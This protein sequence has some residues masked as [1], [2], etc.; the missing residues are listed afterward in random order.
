M[1][2]NTV[3][4]S[5]ITPVFNSEKFIARCI[6]SVQ[7]Q[8]F[9][10]YEYLII[11]GGSTDSTVAKIARYQ[12]KDSRIKI[13]SEHDEGVYDAMNKGISISKGK[14]M[15]FLGSDDYFYSNT[16]LDTIS[17]AITKYNTDI[18]Y[19]DVWHEQLNSVY[20]GC[21][22]IEKLLKHNICHQAIFFKKN[23]FDRIGKYSLKY[24]KK[25]DYNFNLHCW[26]N[27]VKHVYYNEV[28]AFYSTGGLSSIGK[29]VDF[30]KDYPIN[31]VKFLFESIRKPIS[32][33]DILSKI[34]RKVIMRYS[35]RY[36]INF[37]L[38]MDHYGLKIVA[39]VWMILSLPFI[40]FNNF[41]TKRV[42]RKSG[43]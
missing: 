35:F 29:D 10:N 21:F 8:N 24:K 12:D 2:D 17:K 20:D 32:K 38:K 16:V 31:T 39:L 40:V 26:I 9:K 13:Y 28:I 33:I 18:I 41:L 1:P 3:L 34:F 43:Y 37:L 11:D 30:E 19:G 7:Q 6:E 15:Y 25:A 36:F 23:V 5:I 4:F 14:W 22:G 42:F 27:G